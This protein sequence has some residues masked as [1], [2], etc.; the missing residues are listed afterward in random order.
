MH[1]AGTFTENR[2]GLTGPVNGS[3]P[4]ARFTG[5]FIVVPTQGDCITRPLTDARVH[6]AGSFSG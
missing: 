6:M 3:Q 4:G 1:V 2:L 5:R